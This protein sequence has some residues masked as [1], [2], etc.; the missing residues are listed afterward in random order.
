MRSAVRSL[1]RN[2]LI[3]LT[4]PLPVPGTA[5]QRAIR[6]WRSHRTS[7]APDGGLTNHPEIVRS[8]FRGEA[9]GAFL[10]H[11]DIYVWVPSYFSQ[12]FTNPT[13]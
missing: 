7:W 2:S 12:F 11:I 8:N 9:W 13:R 4:I 5:H 10:V 1:R 3:P 6:Q